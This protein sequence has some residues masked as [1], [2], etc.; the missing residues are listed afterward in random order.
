[1]PDGAANTILVV[2]A[3][4]PV[5]W[6]KPHD[7]AFL[8]ANPW[9]P[10]GQGEPLPRLGGLFERGYHALFCDG[11]VRFIRRGVREE[12]LRLLIHRNDGRA[13]DFAELD[14]GGPSGK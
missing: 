2:E 11:S 1:M 10:G 5:P 9:A 14:R 4:E 8:P 13:I 6:T 7:L 12:T 3:A